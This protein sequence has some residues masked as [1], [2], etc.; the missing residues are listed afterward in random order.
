MNVS[1]KI[2]Q[3][4]NQKQILIKSGRDTIT[5]TMISLIQEICLKLKQSLDQSNDK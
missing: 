5:T 1:T 4:V 3:C 2:Y